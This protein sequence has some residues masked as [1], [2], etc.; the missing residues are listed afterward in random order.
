MQ[1]GEELKI[2]T[3]RAEV[4]ELLSVQNVTCL[5]CMI[6]LSPCLLLQGG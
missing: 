3:L 2:M 5:S 4:E 1:E 6:W